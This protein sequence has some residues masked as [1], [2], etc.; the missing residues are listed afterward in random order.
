M[1]G[2]LRRQAGQRHG[3]RGDLV[4][5][6]RSADL[7]AGG[8]AVFDLRGR[9]LVVVQVMVAAVLDT[10][11]ACTFGIPGGHA[12]STKSVTYILPVT[13]AHR[14]GDLPLAFG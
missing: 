2:R 11:V 12:P 8:E 7:V 9:V 4:G 1:V 13:L 3:V 5:V 6:Q 10:L 14:D